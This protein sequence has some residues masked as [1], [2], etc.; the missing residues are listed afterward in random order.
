M[1]NINKAIDRN[2]EEGRSRSGNNRGS[3]NRG[4]AQQY[5]QEDSYGEEGEQPGPRSGN[6]NNALPEDSFEEMDN[7]SAD[8]DM[9]VTERNP[10]SGRQK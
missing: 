10:M 1:N 4:R 5:V 9:P 7:E 6:R 8:Q 3:S 2:R